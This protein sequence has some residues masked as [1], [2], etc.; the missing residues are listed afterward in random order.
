MRILHFSDIHLP[1]RL[2][3][4]PFKD[5]LSKR[6]FGGAN[7]IFGRAGRFADGPEKMVALDDFRREIAADL[8][9]CTGDYTALGT[10]AEL[11][12]A[13]EAVQPLMQAP[14]GYIHV[15][16]NHDLYVFDVLR[17]KRWEESFGDTFKTDL[18]HHLVDGAWPFVQL[19][20]SDLAIVGVNSA[21]PNPLPWRSSGKIPAPQLEALARVLADDAVRGRFIFVITHYA[22]RLEDGGPDRQLHG[23]VN[24]DE[25][26]AVC[27]DLQHGAILCGHVHRRY[28]VRSDGVKPAVFC[29][30]SATQAGAE[31]LW[32]FDIEGGRVRATPGGWRDGGYVLDPD[33]AADV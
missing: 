15:P 8:V 6:I 13:R 33:A 21:Q 26:L 23:L 27:A 20:G 9:I 4:V 3:G 25:F 30:G 1:P 14:G 7:L 19:V 29:A 18:P 12:R 11:R 32:V 17:T 2:L 28:M 24:A 5:W 10:R 16:G 22:P 31:G